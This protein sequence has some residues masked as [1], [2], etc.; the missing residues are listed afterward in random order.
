MLYNKKLIYIYTLFFALN[1]SMYSKAE[2]IYSIPGDQ[3]S[4]P[5]LSDRGSLIE[6][7]RPVSSI[8]NPSKYYKFEEQNAILDPKTK[9]PIDVRMFLVTPVKNAKQ[10]KVTFIL[11]TGEHVTINVFSSIRAQNSYQIKF[12]N[13]SLPFSN[14]SSFL[15]NEKNLMKSMLKDGIEPGFSR[16]ITDIDLQFLQYKDDIKL[17]MVRRYSGAGLTGWVIKVINI[18]EKEIKLNPIALEVGVPNRA[19]LFQIDHKNLSPCSVN[20][21]NNP[22]SNSCVTAIRLVVR[23]SLPTIPVSASDF[24]FMLEK[25]EKSD[26]KG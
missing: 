6:F 5:I 20:A 23:D 25:I 3:I 9:M 21:S 16:E 17:K 7:P 18:T 14:Y 2:V 11:E 15:Q 22:K 24:P 8:A 12:P 19:S 26:N 4:L 10:E 1:I 13:T